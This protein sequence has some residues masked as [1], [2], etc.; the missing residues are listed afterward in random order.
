MAQ[1]VPFGILH[2]HA[3]DR[4]VDEGDTFVVLDVRSSYD[5]H[6]GLRQITIE[7]VQEG[8]KTEAPEDPD[9]PDL[10]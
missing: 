8:E 2:I 6:S 10:D 3:G 9:F 1:P 7:Y 5:I 4:L